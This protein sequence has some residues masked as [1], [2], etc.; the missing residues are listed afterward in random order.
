MSTKKG[1][2]KKSQKYHN[3]IAYEVRFDQKKMEVNSSAP[4]DR[5]CARCL[6][7]IKWKCQYGKYKPATCLSRC[8]ICQQ[9]AI[10]KAYRTVC[11]KCADKEKLCAKC[12]QAKSIAEPP[13]P[14]K[15]SKNQEV[16]REKLAK[17][18]D[19]MEGL[20]ERS[21]RNIMRKLMRGEIEFEG[22]LFVDVDTGE[23]IKGLK[24]KG[25]A[26]ELED[27]W[28]DNDDDDDDFDDDEDMDDDED[29]EEAPKGKGK[30]KEEEKVDTKK[31]GQ[32]PAKK[33]EKEEE[34]QEIASSKPAEKEQGKKNKAPAKPAAKKAQK[35]KQESEDDDDDDFDDDDDD[36]DDF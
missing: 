23:P 6:D 36:L 1:P 12:G 5:L 31:K 7:Q 35:K 14:E 20:R 15:R 19:Y 29:E 2:A 24:F 25:D 8:N 22:G 34:I 21:R 11:D 17:M 30:G 28:E 27:N 4:M 18:E 9:K 16:D 13:K 10:N 32:E 3:K 26:D 33:E